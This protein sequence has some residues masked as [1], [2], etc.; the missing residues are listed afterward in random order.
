VELL[1]LKI[2]GRISEVFE[3]KKV[4]AVPHCS[5]TSCPTIHKLINP[6]NENNN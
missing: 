1:N 3:N 2:S 6:R 4:T 5:V